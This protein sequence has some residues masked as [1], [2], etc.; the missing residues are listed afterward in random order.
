MLPRL[1]TGLRINRAIAPGN[2]TQLGESVDILVGS[3]TA[4]AGG[5]E[6]LTVV[7]NAMIF[8]KG[9]GPGDQR[10]V[11]R[12]RVTRRVPGEHAVADGALTAHVGQR[13]HSRPWGEAKASPPF[14]AP[15]ACSRIGIT[16]RMNVLP[17][18]KLRRHFGPRNTF[19]TG[20]TGTK[21]AGAACF[22]GASQSPT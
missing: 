5:G 2:G 13:Q 1:P 8:Q 22:W 9:R 11:G 15:M 14:F 16:S 17:T 3:E 12:T 10:P 4:L 19:P 6:Q 20:V 21:S 7:D 18:I